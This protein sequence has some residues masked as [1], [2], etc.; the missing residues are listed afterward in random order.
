MKYNRSI[1]VI[2]IKIMIKTQALFISSKRN[3]SLTADSFE[4]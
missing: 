3:A 4:K 2:M 1:R